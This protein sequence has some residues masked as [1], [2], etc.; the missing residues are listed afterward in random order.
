MVEFDEPRGLGVVRDDDGRNYPF[1]CAAIADGTRRI[2]PGTPVVFSVA[3]A[4]RGR[5]EA[6]AVTTVGVS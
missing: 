5:H 1:H 6:R 3:A 4:H 2:E